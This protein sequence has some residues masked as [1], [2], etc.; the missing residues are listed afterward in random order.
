MNFFGQLNYMN[1]T[2]KILSSDYHRI[3][4][5]DIQAVCL[6]MTHDCLQ[7]KYHHK[8]KELACMMLYE[9]LKTLNEKRFYYPR[10]TLLRTTEYC[11]IAVR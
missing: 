3:M 5:M 6:P 4:E 11:C 8:R 9:G 7:S 10:K 1:T 2:R